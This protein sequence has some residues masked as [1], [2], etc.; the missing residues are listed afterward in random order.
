MESTTTADPSQPDTTTTQTDTAPA[1]KVVPLSALQAEREA[2]Q[3]LKAKLAAI[4]AERA[5]QAAE[6]AKA[7]GEWEKL[8]T[9]A[10]PKLAKL[11]EYESRLTEYETREAKAREDRRLKLPEHLRAVIPDGIEP[12]KL[13]AMLTNLEALAAGEGGGRGGDAKART[14]GGGLDPNVLTDAE[15]EWSVGQ[16]WTAGA[17]VHAIR[18]AYK[19]A[20]PTT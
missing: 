7:A 11:T 14:G 17:S 16:R 2:N 10:E 4:E 5:A 18:Y 12:D 3:A 1:D 6:A 13:D 9:E 15:R 19:K 20:H 8:Y